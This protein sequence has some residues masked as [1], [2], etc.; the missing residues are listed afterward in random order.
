MPSSD[1]E[2]KMVMMREK[3]KMKKKQENLTKHADKGSVNFKIVENQ[4]WSHVFLCK[5]EF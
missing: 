2:H 1:D 4:N 3:K 5:I